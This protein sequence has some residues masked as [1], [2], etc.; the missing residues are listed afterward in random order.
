MQSTK[1]AT[2]NLATATP[3]EI[4]TE[5]AR[6]HGELGTLDQRLTMVAKA[7]HSLN[8][9]KPVRHGRKYVYDRNID[10]TLNELALK[11]ADDQ[12]PSWDKGNV[13]DCINEY[14]DLSRKFDATQAQIQAIDV[15]YNGRPWSRFIAVEGGHIHS[16]RFCEGGTIRVTTRIGWHPELSG[17][18]QA[19]AVDLLGELLCTHCFPDA[20]VAW[21]TGVAKKKVA[22]GYCDG[23]GEQ[24]ENLEMQ[25]VSPRGNCPK[26]KQATGISKTGKVLKH[27]LAEA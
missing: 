25:Y 17:K 20:P 6:L 14:G 2:M 3:V 18:S 13:T 4:D 24:G 11:L 23:Q 9:E 22:E 10:E 7:A 15:E 27:R 21:T 8:S 1:G 26:C 5:L 12:F 16:S 19:E